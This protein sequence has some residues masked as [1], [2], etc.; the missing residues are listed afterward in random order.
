MAVRGADKAAEFYKKVFGAE[1]LM[2]YAAPNG[3]IMHCEMKIGD[4]IFMFGEAV[5]QPAYNMNVMLYVQDSDAVFKRAVD[6][7]GS[8]KEPLSDKFYGDRSGRVTDP[9]GNDWT[10]STH[11]EDVPPAEMDRR[12]KAM[13]AGGKP[14]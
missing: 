4:S 2:R 7:G 5:Q 1:E 8:V 12:A 6:A 14:A 9:F 13:M 10:I 3:K 11:K